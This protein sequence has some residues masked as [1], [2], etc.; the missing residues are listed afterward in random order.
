[1]YYMHMRSSSSAAKTGSRVFKFFGKNDCVK[2]CLMVYLPRRYLAYT[3]RSHCSKIMHL[4]KFSKHCRRRTMKQNR[5][6]RSYG[7]Q[8]YFA[9]DWYVRNP[10]AS[11]SACTLFAF[12]TFELSSKWL[13]SLLKVRKLRKLLSCLPTTSS[14]GFGGE[15][16]QTKDT[17]R[18]CRCSR[19]IV[20]NWSLWLD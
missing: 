7:R 17:T 18:Y 1:M 2:S 6:Y 5:R 9:R 11:K 8:F 14:N 13:S 15:C 12:E 4:R 10:K 16:N 20:R 3:T 19:A